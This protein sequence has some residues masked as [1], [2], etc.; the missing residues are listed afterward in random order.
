MTD[1]LDIVTY[2][3]SPTKLPLLRAAVLPAAGWAAGQGLAVHLE[4]HWRHGP[5][6][7]IRLAATDPAGAAEL[8]VVAT[9][10]AGRLRRHLAE[11]PSTART[12][13]AEL[14]AQAE[15]AGRIELVP[16]P[17]APIHPD[18]TVRVEPVDDR[19]LATLFG[20]TE[21]VECRA[22][23]L[24]L[25]VPAVSAAADRLAAAGDSAAARVRTCLTAMALHASRYPL[26]LGNGHQSFL[27][28][29]E[30]FLVLND[31]D[32]RVRA[33]FDA[34]WRRCADSATALVARLAAPTDAAGPGAESGP[35][36][37][38][39]ERG[40]EQ[41]T[42]SAA[43][44]TGAAYQRGELPRVPAFSY[45]DRA[46]QIG[47]PDTVRRWHPD[48]TEY[49]D[50]HQLLRQIDFDRVPYEREFVTYRFATNVLYL[51]LGL[52]DVRPTER[53][54]A[55]Y[56]LSRAAERITGITWQERINGYLTRLAATAPEVTR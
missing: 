17:Y 45:L 52:L 46:E 12:S 15:Q 36:L 54:L 37:D 31:P 40:W 34:Q 9:A 19:A 23:L 28:H 44:V 50:Y 33:A 22:A 18:N 21:A 8:A 1:A 41:W 55:A 11:Q 39:T 51:L 13:V 26:G 3:H 29:L 35:G 14:L 49:S 38:P 27:S 48:R 30:E 56:L 20:S 16:P 10:V 42:V 25:G 2:Y 4:R 53:Y 43:E 7:R 5:H 47:D 6:L 32:G 24:R